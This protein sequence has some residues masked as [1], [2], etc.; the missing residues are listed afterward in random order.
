MRITIRIDDDLHDHLRQEAER[1]SISLTAVV[2]QAIRRGLAELKARAQYKEKTFD[3]GLP[4]VHLTKA[5]SLAD[6]WDD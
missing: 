1:Q 5:L 4:L 3:M 6:Q 2:N